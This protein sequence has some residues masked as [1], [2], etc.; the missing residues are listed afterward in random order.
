MA[1]L[2]STELPPEDRIDDDEEEKVVES[3]KRK[4]RDEDQEVE[5]KKETVHDSDWWNKTG[6]Q[7]EQ[8]VGKDMAD[9]VCRFLQEEQPPV[10]TSPIITQTQTTESSTA[11]AAV[12]ATATTT[13]ESDKNSFDGNN[14]WFVTLP[15]LPDKQVRRT[16]HEWVREK[17]AFCARGDTQPQSQNI[18]IWKACYEAH[19][20]NESRHHQ[21]NNVGRGGGNNNNTKSRRSKSVNSWPSH[22]NDKN[23]LQ[24]CLYK[25]NMDTTAAIKEV[26]RRCLPAKLRLGFAGMKDKRGITTQYCTAYRQRAAHILQVVMRNNNKSN[27]NKAAFPRNTGSHNDASRGSSVMRVGNFRYSSQEI[28]LGMLQG[29]RFQIALRNI[30]MPTAATINSNNS[31]TIEATTKSQQGSSEQSAVELALRQA[32]DA[33]AAHGFINYFGMQRF[34]KFGD[35]HQVGIHVLQ[36]DFKSAIE[37]IMAPKQP[38]DRSDQARRKWVNRFDALT[39]D[40]SSNNEKRTKVE[41]DCVRQI[42]REFGRFMTCENSILQSLARKPLDYQRAFVFMPRTMRMMFVHAVQSLWWN[43]VA[44]R[45]VQL[46]L[47]AQQPLQVMAGDL[48]MLNDPSASA[49]ESKTS[50]HPVPHVVTEEDV[51]QQRYTMSDVV[52]PLMGSKSILPQN[53]TGMYCQQLLMEHGLTLA[54]FGKVADHEVASKGDYRKL[55]CVPSAVEYDIIPYHDPMEPL[56]QT[57][58]MKLEG[59]ELKVQIPSKTTKVGIVEPGTMEGQEERNTEVEEASETLETL[60]SAVMQSERRAP[61]LAMVINFTLPSSAY[62]TIALRELMKRPTSFEYQKDLKMDGPVVEDVNEC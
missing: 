37:V 24:F 13:T 21:L 26:A 25:E 38:P 31:N 48:V 59:I 52:L 4:Q 19:M 20:P 1:E 27:S 34:G 17:L 42:Q 41:G 28:S 5:E 18:R 11:E 47:Q 2:T 60:A 56:I 32:A 14:V 33:F 23:Y 51:Q 57:D 55:L 6:A 62:A 58:L 12:N 35:T 36:G 44:T 45:R 10:A 43:H 49:A 29:N 50:Q 22:W 39:G 16:V 46:Q 40:G 30:Q 3:R 54:M 53:E 15:P 7:L 61:L 8:W 9:Q